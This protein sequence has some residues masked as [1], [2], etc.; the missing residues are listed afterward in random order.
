MVV[1]NFDVYSGKGGTQYRI[2]GLGYDIVMKFSSPIQGL[3][4]D[5]AQIRFK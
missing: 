2:Y 4:F 1:L 3:K 5:V